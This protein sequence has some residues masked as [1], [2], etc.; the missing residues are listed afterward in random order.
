MDKVVNIAYY[1]DC[2]ED[3][4][5]EADSAG[6]CRA[7][8]LDVFGSCLSHWPDALCS[9]RRKSYQRRCRCCCC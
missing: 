6:D 1:L 7:P 8:D 2:P 4:L 5:D 3:I 9:S